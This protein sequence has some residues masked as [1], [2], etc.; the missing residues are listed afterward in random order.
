[1]WNV[2]LLFSE[3]FK[4]GSNQLGDSQHVRGPKPNAETNP[5]GH[6]PWMASLGFYDSNGDWDH[7]CG[8]TLISHS[9]F[10]TAAHCINDRSGVCF[11]KHKATCLPD[12]FFDTRMVI[13]PSAWAYRLGRTS[14][15]TLLVFH[16]RHGSD[17]TISLLQKITIMKCNYLFSKAGPFTL[18][19]TTWQTWPQTRHQS[20]ISWAP[21]WASTRPSSIRA[22]T[23]CQPT[24]TSPSSWLTTW[25]SPG[26]S[27]QSVCRRTPV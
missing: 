9:H 6:W 25:R 13:N 5:V 23:A 10:L 16:D 22:T 14:I 4:C 2:V 1:M 21:I 19:I 12:Y 24:S 15:F 11:T 7:Q 27:S 8:A 17:K 20:P 3:E 18:E 26:T